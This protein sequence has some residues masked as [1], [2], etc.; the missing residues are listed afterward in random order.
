MRQQILN[1][2]DSMWT[3][4]FDIEF[5]IEQLDAH[6]LSDEELLKLFVDVVR[7]YPFE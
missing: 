1:Y 4:G 3:P 5:N 6:L 7:K 2:L